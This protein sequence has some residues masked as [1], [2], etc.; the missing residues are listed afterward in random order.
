MRRLGEADKGRAP[1][2]Q[3]QAYTSTG[4][5]CKPTAD[6]LD[7][8]SRE[9][10]SCGLIRLWKFFSPPAVSHACQCHF[11]IW[12][13]DIEGLAW[14][15]AAAQMQGSARQPLDTPAQPSSKAKSTSID[16]VIFVSTMLSEK[17]L[18]GSHWDIASGR[19]WGFMVVVSIDR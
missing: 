8:A 10:G 15:P 3:P 18:V 9:L 11:W 16:C 4:R 14:T 7:M 1:Q 5:P 19:W 6:I 2:A 13:P 12:H 17:G